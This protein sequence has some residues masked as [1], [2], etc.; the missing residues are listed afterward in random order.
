MKPCGIE[1]MGVWG[2]ACVVCATTA[3]AGLG[4]DPMRTELSAR[5]GST[6]QGAIALTNEKDTPITLDVSFQ[7][8]SA[9]ANVR[10]DWIR[11]QCGQRTLKPQETTTV[12]YTLAIPET[13]AGEFYGRVGFSEVPEGATPGAVSIQTKISVPLFVTI[14]GT[15]RY[16]A[17][18]QAVALKS[19]DP[20]NV[21]V[22]VENSGNVH[23]RAVGECTILDRATGQVVQRFP[24]NEQKFPL[25]PGLTNRLVARGGGRLEPGAYSCTI[26]I[27]FPDEERAVTKTVDLNVPAGSP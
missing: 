12:N 4:I 11:I 1:R 17:Q 24:V 22:L 2:L 26:R 25:Y 27:P 10:Q 13:A 15:E 23:L 16:Q 3:G 8:R 5:P 6:V 9:L 7:E 21:E 19:H 14:E 18:I 20:V